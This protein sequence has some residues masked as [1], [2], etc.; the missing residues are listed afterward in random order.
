MSFNFIMLF[1]FLHNSNYR[2]SCVQKDLRRSVFSACYFMKHIRCLFLVTIVMVIV[3]AIVD[4][5]GGFVVVMCIVIV[6]V[7]DACHHHERQRRQRH[8]VSDR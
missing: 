6:I 1:H 5:F 3:L 8:H 4:V 7:V 2:A